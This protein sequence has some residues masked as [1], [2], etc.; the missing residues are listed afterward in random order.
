MHRIEIDDEV[1][2]YL[3]S[4]AR[5][6]ETPN[7]VLRRELPVKFPATAPLPKATVV[8]GGLMKLI[9]RGLVAPGE[10]LTHHQPRK[11]RSFTAKIDEHGWIITDRG[12]FKDPSPALGALVGTAINGK[13]HW[14]HKPSGKSIKELE[15]AAGL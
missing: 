12:P 11:R 9:D 13:K 3:E 4:R 6:F 7:D 2:K 8:P 10:E 15:E 14:V 5:G 1:Y